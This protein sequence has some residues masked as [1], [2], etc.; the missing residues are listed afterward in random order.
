MSTRTNKK[1]HEAPF[2]KQTAIGLDNSSLD[3]IKWFVNALKMTSLAII[4]RLDDNNN[5][6]NDL[7]NFIFP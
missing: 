4:K 3:Y 7:T 1:H 5:N 6:N 2:S